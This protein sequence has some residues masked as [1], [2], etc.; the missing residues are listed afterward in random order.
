MNFLQPVSPDAPHP[1]QRDADGGG[2]MGGSTEFYAKGQHLHAGMTCA[3]RVAA[4]FGTAADLEYHAEQ[5]RLHQV[6]K[7][8]A[9]G[10][11]WLKAQSWFKE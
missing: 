8:S 7:A 10:Q 11:A 4:G 3:E 1:F 9:E 2:T 6:W 5:N